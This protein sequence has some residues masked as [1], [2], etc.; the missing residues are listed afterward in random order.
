MLKLEIL[1]VMLLLLSQVRCLLSKTLCCLY[2]ALDP[3]FCNCRKIEWLWKQI[4]V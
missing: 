4:D 1:P 3:N 2:K